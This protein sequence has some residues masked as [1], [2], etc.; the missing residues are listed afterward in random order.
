MILCGTNEAMQEMENG[1]N[2]LWLR[3]LRRRAFPKIT[4]PNVAADADILAFAAHFGLGEDLPL[5]AMEEA[6]RIAAEDGVG[7]LITY[8]QG[9]TRMAI[10][11]RQAVSWEHF[12]RTMAAFADQGIL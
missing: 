1:P 8:L 2:S 11:E 12:L 5:D 4:L 6:R 7:L 10:A 9:A 3:Q